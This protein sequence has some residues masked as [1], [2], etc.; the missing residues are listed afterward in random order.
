MDRDET[1]QRI[2]PFIL[3]ELT[4]RAKDLTKRNKEEMTQDMEIEQDITLEDS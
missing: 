4:I 2:K 1:A 3:S